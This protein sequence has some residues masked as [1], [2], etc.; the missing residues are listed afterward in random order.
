MSGLAGWWDR[1][2]RPLD[3]FGSFKVKTGLLVAGAITLAALT[4]RLGASWKFR[5]A[6]LAALV[7]S[8]IFTQ[9]V[10]H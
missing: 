3:P 10:A 7:T 1:L 6:L 8:L 9:F 2:P 5:Y 4:F